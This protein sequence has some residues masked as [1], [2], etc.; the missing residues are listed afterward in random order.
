MLCPVTSL[1]PSFVVARFAGAD[2]TISHSSD[3]EQ[4]LGIVSLESF[5]GGPFRAE[6]SSLQPAS[7]CRATLLLSSSASDTGQ[8]TI[9]MGLV[10][11]NGPG[12]PIVLG[13]GGD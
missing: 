1:L 9:L 7:G 6:R 4:I 10:A 11:W 5:A 12:S 8:K 2:R 13:I 3:L